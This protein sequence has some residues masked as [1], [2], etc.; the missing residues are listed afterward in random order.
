MA[1]FN[2]KRLRELRLRAGYTQEE[3]AQRSGI[4]LR[5]LSELETRTSI[6]PTLDTLSRLARALDVS[7]SELIMEEE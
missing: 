6:N 5:R 4:T 3:L 2:R 7:V 1:R